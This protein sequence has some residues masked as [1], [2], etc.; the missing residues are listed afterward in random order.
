MKTIL[1]I[2]CV[3]FSL[4]TL[5]AQSNYH[6]ENNT[7]KYLGNWYH[8]GG[9]SMKISTNGNSIII[10][11]LMGGQ[12]TNSFRATLIDGRLR[13]GDGNDYEYIQFSK[14]YENMLLV[15]EWEYQYIKDDED[16]KT[17]AKGLTMS[18]LSIINKFVGKW[19]NKEDGVYNRKCEILI[20]DDNKLIYKDITNNS[21][22]E[23]T[24]SNGNKLLGSIQYEGWFNKESFSLHFENGI[25]NYDSAETYIKYKKE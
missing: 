12:K 3:V 2:I 19:D 23:L 20:T 7:S 5:N 10:T 16:L 1:T 21:R 22:C 15:G 13:Y 24:L 18:D 11:D 4:A 17:R 9:V 14:D 6:K 8:E 25:L